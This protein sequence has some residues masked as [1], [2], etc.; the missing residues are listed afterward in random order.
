M[1]AA[2]REEIYAALDELPVE[3]VQALLAALRRL[4]LDQPIRRWSAAIGTLSHAEAEEMRR[5]IEEGCEKVD[6]GSW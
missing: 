3:N 6:P 2:E 5:I 4:R 1:T